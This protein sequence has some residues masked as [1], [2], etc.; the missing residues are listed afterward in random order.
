M[1]ALGR[2][3]G[4]G[5]FDVSR[6]EHDPRSLDALIWCAFSTTSR[7][8]SSGMFGAWT[9]RETA[10]PKPPESKIVAGTKLPRRQERLRWRAS[11]P[12][13]QGVEEDDEPGSATDD[14]RAH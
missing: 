5:V 2:T 11:D 6:V 7:A 8:T 4:E 10:S 13:P 1:V 14:H 9:S 12:T 3:P